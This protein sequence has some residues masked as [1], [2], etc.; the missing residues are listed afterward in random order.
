[1]PLILGI[2]PGLSGGLCFLSAA[3]GQPRRV[4]SADDIPTFGVDAKRR[5]DALAV[6]KLIQACPPDFA[7]IERAQAMPDQGSS[8]GFNYGRAVGALEAVVLGMEIPLEIVEVSAWKKA[9]GLIKTDKEASRQKALL[10]FPDAHAFIAR[11]K[12]HGRAE[13]MLLANYGAM[14]RR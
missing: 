5:V 9:H 6:A 8:S 3:S 10:L 4:I 1:M 2:D 7:V 14:L 13:A 12:D 11:K